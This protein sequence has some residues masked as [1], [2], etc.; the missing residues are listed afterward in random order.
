[1]EIQPA[2]SSVSY[3]DNSSSIGCAG[4]NGRT[5]LKPF[6]KHP[7]CNHGLLSFSRVATLTDTVSSKNEEDS[8]KKLQQS[9]N[10]V[11]GKSRKRSRPFSWQRNKSHRKSNF[12]ESNDETPCITICPD[13]DRLCGRLQCVFNNRVSLHGKF[14]FLEESKNDL[15]FG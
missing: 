9:S 12:E 15:D 10:Q 5:Y 6:S 2:N 1:M 13:E 4:S 3:C 11:T 7:R 8:D 14:F